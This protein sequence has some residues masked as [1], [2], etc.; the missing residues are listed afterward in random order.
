M[1]TYETQ[2]VRARGVYDRSDSLIY[3]AWFVESNFPGVPFYVITPVCSG[4]VCTVTNESAGTSDTFDKFDLVDDFGERRPILTRNGIT[5]IEA[6][7]ET[8]ADYE[9]ASDFRSYGSWLSHSAFAVETF[10]LNFELDDG[11]D[12]KLNVRAALVGGD[13]TGTAP[14]GPAYWRGIMVGTTHVGADRGEVLQGDASLAFHMEDGGSMDAAFTDIV[15]LDRRALHPIGNVVF[16]DV[17]VAADGTYRQGQ[18]GNRIH[19]AFYGP[20]HTET[21]GIFEHS[22]IV[23]AFGAKRQ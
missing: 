21:A 12:L 13:L 2:E 1:E 5:T 19:G 7:N 17:P 6:F 15:N 10:S 20:D 22:T 4:P 11:F 3:S 8:V 9:E 18:L 14:A 23:A 16:K